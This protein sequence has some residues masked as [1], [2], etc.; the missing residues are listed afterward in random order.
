MQQHP[1]ALPT[2]KN[3]ARDERIEKSISV[4]LVGYGRQG[5]M[6]ADALIRIPGVHVA[7]IADIWPWRRELAKNR[8]R[9]QRVL[10][11]VYETVEEL[12]DA[13]GAA[14]DAVIVATPDWQHVHHVSACLKAN[15][16]VYCDGEISDSSAKAQELVK[17][18][19]EKKLLVQCGHQRRS[20]P[21]YQYSI[22]KLHHEYKI[23]NV[24]T[25]AYTQWHK[26]IAPLIRVP[27]R[28]AMSLTDLQRHG[29]ENMEQLL[30]WEW[31]SRFGLGDVAYRTGQKLDL[32]RWFW[33]AEPVSV[34]SLGSNDYYNR[35]ALDFLMSIFTFKLP[36]GEVRRGYVQV[37]STNSRGGEYDL[38]SGLMTSEAITG[39]MRIIQ[40]LCTCFMSSP[41]KTEEGITLYSGYGNDLDG[42]N[43]QRAV[44]DNILLTE[45]TPPELNR[46]YF[47][48]RSYKQYYLNV[49]A[50][51]CNPTIL[52][53]LENFISAIRDGTKLRDP[54]EQATKN[55]IALEAAVQSAH[56]RRTIDLPVKAL[57]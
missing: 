42:E 1:T 4:A 7:A 26:G 10:T 40:I 13:E 53:H 11:R 14:I 25:H 32:L 28:L 30:N 12:L 17:L 44:C 48:N 39:K 57:L 56:E 18:A 21:R 35:E 24:C 55:L 50:E 15:K 19:S 47:C 34:T 31:F 27:D 16:H 22:D 45:K 36:T 6:I 46:P 2:F 37:L 20:N 8:R 9:S 41:M 49:P 43:I 33:D 5:E 38:F 51:N 54:I 3:L 23:P 52:P 29:Y